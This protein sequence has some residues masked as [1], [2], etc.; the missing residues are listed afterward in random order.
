MILDVIKI[1]YMAIKED[2]D[3]VGISR[4]ETIV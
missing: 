1:S 4:L 2:R 3:C